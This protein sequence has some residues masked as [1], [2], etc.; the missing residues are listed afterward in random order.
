MAS[1]LMSNPGISSESRAPA[2]RKKKRDQIPAAQSLDESK[3][4]K[5]A[6]EWKSEAQQRAYSSKL[7]RALRQVRSN[8]SPGPK[9]GRAVH[10]VA[11]RV[12]AVAAK[13]RTRWSRAI[14]TSR[15]RLKFTKK[16]GKRQR[17]VSPAAAT[18]SSR[19][20][21]NS[22]LNI[23]RLK[24]KNLPAVQRKARVLGRLVPGCRKEELPVILEEATD[25]IAA[26][27][28][29]VRAM[30]ALAHLLSASGDASSSSGNPLI[31]LSSG[32]PPQT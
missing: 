11:D 22:R 16:H 29:Q 25:Y 27:E 18:G 24:T 4:H 2:T 21:K 26:L 17:V 15:L 5:P 1:P 6:V 20:P 19:L 9:G 12:L 13:G 31:P 28:M 23:L 32:R 8:P 30:S 3:N 10:E 7:L 14:L